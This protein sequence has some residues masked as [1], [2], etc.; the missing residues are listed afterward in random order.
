MI[1]Y[2]EDDGTSNYLM[3]QPVYRYFKKNAISDQISVW[4]SK[5]SSNNSIKPLGTSNNTPQR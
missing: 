3:F 5:G 4:K 1:I 2:F